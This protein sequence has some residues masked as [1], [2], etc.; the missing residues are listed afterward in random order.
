ML[1]NSTIILILTMTLPYSA[2]MQLFELQH[3]PDLGADT[4]S[5]REA[6]REAL[7]CLTT[8]P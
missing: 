5:S 6:Q 1:T 8:K 4:V 7:V 2:S 3:C